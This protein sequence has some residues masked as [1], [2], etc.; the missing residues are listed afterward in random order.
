MS[1]TLRDILN[2]QKVKSESDAITP[3]LPMTPVSLE[4]TGLNRILVEDLICKLLLAHGSLSGREIARLLA[5]PL[6]IISDLLYD[7]KQRL[8]LAYQDTAGV[9]DFDYIL[10]ETGRE[11]GLSARE[12]SAYIGAA[13]VPFA[14]YLESV[15]RQT[16]RSEHP[17][18]AQLEAALKGLVLPDDFFQLLGPAINSAKGLFIYGAPGNGKTE[19]AT[20]IADCYTDTVF[21]PRTLLVGGHLIQLYDPRCHFEVEEEA[22]KA[23][24]TLPDKR[25]LRIKRPA[26]VV[27]GEMDL[28]SLEV[29]FNAHTGICEASLQLKGNSGVFVVDD[30]G[31]QRIGPDKLLNRWILPLEKSIDFLTLP[32]GSKVQVPFNAFLVFCSN[33]DP[34][35]ILEEAFLRKIPYKIF[36]DDPDER[37]FVQ[38]FRQMTEQY[39]IA[40]EADCVEYLLEKHFR[41]I[42][43]MRGCHPRDILQQLIHIA[44]YE[45]RP[46]VM[47]TADLD[48][49][50]QL[51]F[52][53]MDGEQFTQK[54]AQIDHA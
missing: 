5:L 33:F 42:R 18:K 29:G 11:K 14:D 23:L 45:N 19:V 46:P 9:N 25:W 53:V 43:S 28:D 51:Y 30:F 44:R 54:T 27:G 32:D 41:N 22:D 35:R 12:Q 48:R 3:F 26:V 47:T 31:R 1:L 49:A 17:G 40:Y 37:A 34:G 10:T 16:I 52:S 38:I 39:D 15:E 8:I 36:M 13:P 2:S 21:I 50:V 7:L 6:K 24:T 20:R 4:E